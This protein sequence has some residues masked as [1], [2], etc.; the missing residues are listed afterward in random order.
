MVF[1]ETF[2]TE[3]INIE[4][5]YGLH[6][7][8]RKTDGRPTGGVS[9]YLRPSQGNF[10][11]IHKDE[12]I[13]TVRT[14]NV[15]I[16]AAYIRPQATTEE[17]I[18]TLI[19]A[20][21]GT[22]EDESV[23][24]VGDINCRIDKKNTKTE[25]VLETLREEGY[26]LTNKT[27]LPTYIAHNGTSA[28]DL[29]LY[30][31]K[32]LR[33]I[34]QKG[35][36]SSN[37]A[38]IRKHV[39]IATRMEKTKARNR[40]NKETLKNRI[41]RKL[42]VEQIRKN[43]QNIEKAKER[44]K[45][46]HLDKA[47]DI[48]N[49]LIRNACLPTSKRRAQP[50]FDRICYTERK[51]TLKA[52]NKAKKSKNKDDLERYAQKR[53]QYKS[54]IK[55]KRNNYIEMK[56]Q[57]LAEEAE[58]DP[59]M[60]LRRK[61]RGVMKE[62]PI[63]DWENHFTKILNEGNRTEAYEANTTRNPG[64]LNLEREIT[65]AEIN[66][67]VKEAKMKKATGPDQVAYE[68]LKA[69]AD[70]LV[71]IWKELFN[72]C[73]E[74]RV[75]PEQWRRATLKILYKGKGNTG[76]MN[77][78][79]GVALENTLFKI[80]MKILTNRLTDITK[81]SIP[82]N[83]FGFRKEKST[84]QAA[85]ALLHEIEAALNRPKG[86][87]YVVFIDYEKAFDYINREKL[88]TKM[89]DMIG[90]DHPIAEIVHDIMRR[91]WLQITDEVATSDEVMQTNGILQG[92]PISPL[93]FNI[94]T[95]DIGKATTGTTL[96]MYADDMAIGAENKEELQKGID[97]IQRWATEN[98]F[99]INSKKT[100]QMVFKK[101]GRAAASDNLTLGE[102]P[103]QMVNKF[104]YL[105]ITLQ[106]TTKS[107]SA[108]VQERTAAAI[109]AM[110]SIKGI[111]SLKLGTAMKLFATVITPI[112]T[113]GIEL[114]WEKL[115][116]SDLERIEKVKPRFIKKALGV[117]KYTPNRMAYA[118]ARETFFLEDLRLKI[119][120]T[121]TE[122]YKKVIEKKK[123]REKE[124]DEE[125]YASDAMVNRE[126]TGSN[127][128]QRHRIIGLATHGYHHKMCKN[129]K[130]HQPSDSCECKIC[131]QKCERYHYKQCRIWT[132]SLNELIKDKS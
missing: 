23:I 52:L 11:V 34:E 15:T 105:G 125:F 119:L 103:I 20:I 121:A 25:V 113:Y 96:V 88:L 51:A 90:N 44:I 36:W 112:V 5:F 82:E 68:H 14:D 124:I 47:L 130:F 67:C 72:K 64:T 41:S 110:C 10:R 104:R 101:G 26:T 13:L 33:L 40:P 32:D 108:H 29:L 76:D 57:Q 98:A 28:I 115:S 63:D 49:N 74:K 131:D 31:G 54:I 102:E 97:G 87:Y 73:L 53:K 107:F 127:Q 91:N 43:T 95:A 62:I 17:V 117:S 77:S 4:G 60:V 18:E 35:L 50:W 84:L 37:L 75:I 6:S 79:R 80:F 92:D 12:D 100:V 81:L 99:K 22:E 106:P 61:P 3:Q 7:Y 78:Y 58:K 122:P 116:S 69:S 123:Q 2:A 45:E 128:P 132:G 56:A 71:P 19:T 118:L 8:G 93:L 55:N 66:K 89:R 59:F 42:D 120:L 126:W 21:A 16:V 27:E 1:T 38:P 114:I 129:T 70:V 9:C 48:T 83:Q 30:K 109:R 39:P 46:G 86:K 111:T 94:M 24:I 65:E 85:S